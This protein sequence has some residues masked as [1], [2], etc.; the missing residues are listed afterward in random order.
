MTARRVLPTVGLLA[1][2][3]G[4]GGLPPFLSGGGFP[5]PVG[6][7]L[8]LS[9]QGGTHCPRSWGGTPPPPGRTGATPSQERTWDKRPGGT[10]RKYLGP[11]TP[12]KDLDQGPVSRG[13]LAAPPPPPS[14][15]T[16]WKHYL[17][18][19]SVAVGNYSHSCLFQHW[20]TEKLK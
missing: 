19:T 15:L 4:G 12:E 14:E 17:P 6:E 1:L 9:F 20:P 2:L 7:G 5:C 18:I 3:S 13:T 11:G 16:K 10:P 8:P